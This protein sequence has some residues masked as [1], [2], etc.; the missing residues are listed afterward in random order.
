MA[1]KSAR[2]LAL[3]LAAGK[4]SRMGNS[5]PKPLVLL[6]HQPLISYLIHT[7]RAISVTDIALVVGYGADLVVGEIGDAVNYYIRQPEQLGTGHAVTCALKLI[8]QYDSV[9]ILMG[10]NPLLSPKTIQNMLEIQKVTNSPAV[11]LTGQFD[12]HFPYARVVRDDH[13]RLIKC[14]EE[15]DATVDEKTITEYMTSQFLFAVPVLL[16]MLPQ[17]RPHP[18]T[19]ETYLT[20]LINYYVQAGYDVETVIAENYQELVGLNTPEEVA[21]AENYLNSRTK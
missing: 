16:E 15:R 1:E 4:G 14:V 18:Q 21:W 3:I 11:I 6:N 17:L 9:L 19:G 12:R 5:L 2:I 20:D 10:D 7:V 13:H 8:E